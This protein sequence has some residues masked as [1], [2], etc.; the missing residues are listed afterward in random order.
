MAKDR[1]TIR[2]LNPE[3]LLEARIL[4]LQTGRTLGETLNHAL[5]YYLSEELGWMEEGEQHLEAA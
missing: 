2:N 1:H 3:L 4:A 5:E